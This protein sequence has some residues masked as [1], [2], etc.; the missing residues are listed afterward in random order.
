MF[1]NKLRNLEVKVPYLHLE[2]KTSMSVVWSSTEHQFTPQMKWELPG[3]DV[4]MW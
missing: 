2:M 3:S 1:L 4:G